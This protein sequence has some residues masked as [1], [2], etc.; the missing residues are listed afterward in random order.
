MV[1]STFPGSHNQLTACRGLQKS[2]LSLPKIQLLNMELRFIEKSNK[3]IS[4]KIVDSYFHRIILSGIFL[5]A[6]IPTKVRRLQHMV[7]V[8]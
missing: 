5:S 8:D 1:L 3:N 6:F 2:C 7:R 4:A